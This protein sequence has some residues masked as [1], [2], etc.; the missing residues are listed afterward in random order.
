MKITKNQLTIIVKKLLLEAPD[1]LHPGNAYSPKLPGRWSRGSTRVKYGKGLYLDIPYYKEGWCAAADENLKNYV[2]NKKYSLPYRYMINSFMGVKNT[3]T[4]KDFSKNIDLAMINMISKTK[5]HFSQDL[6]QLRGTQS[7]FDIF[8]VEWVKKR[9]DKKRKNNTWPLKYPVDW[10]TWDAINVGN[11]YLPKK[12]G[13][14][15]Q[16]GI[17][18]L[19]VIGKDPYWQISKSLGRFWIK[20]YKDYYLIDDTWNWNKNMDDKGHEIKKW[21]FVYTPNNHGCIA[22]IINDLIFTKNLEYGKIRAAL[23]AYEKEGITK[24]F[25]TKLKYSK[26]EID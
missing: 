25:S 10:R 15:G 7:K 12:Y 22:A 17:P 9:N 16:R 18:M 5:N 8:D 6:E 21:G 4:R 26:S 2:L 20:E 23:V 11:E 3:F 13:E 19:D 24:S 1:G 14:I